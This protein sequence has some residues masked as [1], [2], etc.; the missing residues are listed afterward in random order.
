MTKLKLQ[1]A[2][3]VTLGILT[4][5]VF[6]IV[7]AAAYYGSFISAPTLITLTILINIIIWL[8]S[9]WFSDIIQKWFYK[10]KFYR[11]E[12]LKSESWMKIV[13][14]ICNKHNINMPKIGIIDDL[15][16]TAF[17][18]GSASYNARIILTKGL[19][20]FL[21]EKELEAVIAHELGHI[22]NKDFI[23]MTI[24]ATLL[25]LLYQFYVIFARTRMTGIN[26]GKRGEEKKGD[27]FIILG[28]IS[29]VFY[30]IG[31]YLLMY[32]SRTR[33]YYADEFS[34]K[35]TGD[36]NLL[37][38]ALIKIA[39]GIATIPDT[40]ATTSLLNSTRT[41]GIFDIKIAKEIGLIHANVKDD[42]RKLEKSL[43]YDLV[44]PWA[45]LKEL[46]STHPLVGKR[47]DALC[48]FT[49]KPAYDFEKIKHQ[50]YNKEKMWK[51]FGKDILINYMSSLIFL[52]FL[53][54]IPIGLVNGDYT[55]FVNTTLLFI[56]LGYMYYIRLNYKFPMGYGFE[57]KE[58]ID[59]MSDIYA[60]PVRGTPVK[61]EGKAIGKGQAGY[62]FSEDM[63]FQDKTGFIYLNFESLFGSIGNFFFAWQKL[64]KLL[65][66]DAKANGWF[67]RGNTHHLELNEF[68]TNGYNIKSYTR[69]WTIVGYIFSTFFLTGTY[70]FLATFIIIT[71]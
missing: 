43:L 36:P 9:P 15:N 33:E 23:I 55:L 59:C 49:N 34:A 41:Q 67:F 30:Y 42:K 61:F 47:I 46:S 25:Q 63:I 52:V 5:F 58:I 65:G 8:V 38:S 2:S 20:K 60:S 57:K 32:L 4:G 26:I 68:N 11:P 45:W 18:Y 70:W 29:L 48:K 31:T 27:P 51:K 19:F 7:F 10:T 66:L 54:L 14:K 71:G 28:L 6:S 12:Q 50:E 39:Y 24:A 13:E 37:S 1:F 53:I 40:P 22:V 69:M 35:E 62:I 21:N 64:E 44:N 3:L 17:T 56:I 16:P